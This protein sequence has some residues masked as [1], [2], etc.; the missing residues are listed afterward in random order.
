ML[1]PERISIFN[2]DLY[3]TSFIS[4]SRD[5]CSISSKVRASRTRVCRK[6]SYPVFRL[7]FFQASINSVFN[8]LA[9]HSLPCLACCRRSDRRARE[10]NS[11]RKKIEGRIGKGQG[12]DSLSPPCS[13]PFSLCTNYLDP[14][15]LAAALYYL[16]AW[17]RRALALCKGV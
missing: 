6:M 17:N 1:E 4:R 14:H 13:P 8:S 5:I 2:T 7:A 15:H 12:R 16:K 3:N 10:K 11:R 9:L